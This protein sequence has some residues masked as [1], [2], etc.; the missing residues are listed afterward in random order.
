MEKVIMNGINQT[1]MIKLIQ[2]LTKKG[3]PFKVYFSY[4]GLAICAPNG[5]WDVICHKYS[6]GHERGLLELKS[7]KYIHTED[8]IRGWMSA[9]E[10][11]CNIGIN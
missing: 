11:V 7:Y 6:Y 10:V 5:E 8:N 4:D 3:V 1:E 9:D 2:I